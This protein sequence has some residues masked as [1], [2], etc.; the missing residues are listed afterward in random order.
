MYKLFFVFH[1]Q[2]RC[3]RR[4]PPAGPEDPKGYWESLTAI[5]LL[6]RT[7]RFSAYA[8][9]SKCLNPLLTIRVYIK[10]SN[11]AWGPLWLSTT[12]NVTW[13]PEKHNRR[14]HEFGASHFRHASVHPNKCDL[15]PNHWNLED[16]FVSNSA[17][18]P[19]TAPWREVL[20]TK[21]SWSIPK[22][23]LQSKEGSGCFFQGVRKKNWQNLTFHQW[24]HAWYNCDAFG[25]KNLPSGAE[26]DTLGIYNT[27]IHA[28]L[29]PRKTGQHGSP[30]SL[31]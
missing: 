15:A 19:A 22:L 26:I 24:S 27:G 3:R 20:S 23:I 7:R 2:L 9:R 13:N 25:E 8:R 29:P 30:E 21:T 31:P 4:H 1:D 16:F 5:G 28:V 12:L 17:S 6:F 18:S 14:T 11:P 10:P